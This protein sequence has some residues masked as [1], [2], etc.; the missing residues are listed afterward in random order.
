MAPH[1][2]PAPENENIQRRTIVA[3]AA[4]TIPVIATALAAPSAAASPNAPTL[5]FTQSSYTA[6]GCGTL[7]GVQVRRTTDGSTADAGESVTVTLPAG[8][9]INGSSTYTGTTDAAGLITL[10]PISVP[11]TGG[12]ATFT[13]SSDALNASASVTSTVA[14]GLAFQTSSANGYVVGASGVPSGSTPIGWNSYLT[15]NGEVWINGAKRS[16]NG[17]VTQAVGELDGGN[18]YVG[19]VNSTGNTVKVSSANGYA[20]TGGGAPVGSTAL[21][22]NAF[23]SPAGEVWINGTKVSGSHVVSQAVAETDGGNTYVSWVDTDGKAFGTNSANGYVIGASGVPDGSTAIGWNAYLTSDGEVWINGAKRSGAGVVTQ[24]VGE[25]DGGNTYVSYVNSTGD[26]V[27]VT[28]ANGYALTGGGAPVGSTAL[29]WNAF[30][31]LAG[32]VWVNGTKVS[33]NH[34]VSQAVAET[35]G[36]NTYVSWVDVADCD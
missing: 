20:L 8:Y 23:L 34:V 5:A 16:G 21:G 6:T 1:T 24:A 12:T 11:A 7:T 9:T 2:F 33:G 29:G 36:G 4:W 27:K 13:A 15:S 14:D 10:P 18:T 26:T 3:G 32:E 19:Y 35:D 17:V 28:S 25:L 22:W 30:L 31:S